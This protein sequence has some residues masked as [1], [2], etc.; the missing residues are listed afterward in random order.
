MARRCGICRKESDGCICGHI[1]R[2]GIQ[3]DREKAVPV[4][5]T[6]CSSCAENLVK[7]LRDRYL[8]NWEE[9]SDSWSTP[10]WDSD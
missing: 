3:F 6:I 7:R 8:R 10:S 5:V 2:D 4:P 9:N 1:V